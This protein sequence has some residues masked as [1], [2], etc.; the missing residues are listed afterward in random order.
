[1]CAKA[2]GY[3]DGCMTAGNGSLEVDTL[4]S[5]GSLISCEA[6]RKVGLFDEGFFIDHVETE[7]CFLCEGVWI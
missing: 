6:L 1:M 4:N 7:W 2:P 3:V 5:S